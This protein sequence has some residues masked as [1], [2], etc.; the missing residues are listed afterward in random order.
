MA[1]TSASN[2]GSLNSCTVE[3]VFEN[4]LQIRQASRSTTIPINP[5]NS[6]ENMVTNIT[7]GPT[8]YHT[9]ALNMKLELWEKNL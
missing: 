7:E 9:G 6:A 3:S 4:R 5:P 2:D 8:K 1:G